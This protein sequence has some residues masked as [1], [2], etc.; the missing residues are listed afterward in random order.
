[1]LTLREAHSGF[2]AGAT[3]RNNNTVNISVCPTGE[4]SVLVYV[5]GTRWGLDCT[6]LPPQ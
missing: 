2:E 1:M 5:E 6:R 4:E 3:R